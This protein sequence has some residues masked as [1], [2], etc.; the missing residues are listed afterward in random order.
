MRKT[1]NEEKMWWS[2]TSVFSPLLTQ[3]VWLCN[4]LIQGKAT[5]VCPY[6][7]LLRRRQDIPGCSGPGGAWKV[8]SGS[9]PGLPPVSNLPPPQLF[10]TLVSLSP[11]SLPVLQ[12]P[13][14]SSYASCFCQT[15]FP[16]HFLSLA[17]G[18]KVAIDHGARLR[19]EVKQIDRLQVP[20]PEFQ[21]W[22]C[23]LLAGR[24]LQS[25][26]CVPQALVSSSVKWNNNGT[27]L[28]NLWWLDESFMVSAWHG[29]WQSWMPAN[30]II[31][32]LLQWISTRQ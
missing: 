27:K 22:C 28:R 23:S 4:P 7:H 12:T 9:S 5:Q 25:P 11:S 21:V 32:L 26:T 3:N 29:S 18:F 10:L 19:P 17:P 1:L 8:P 6:L 15:A 13:R 14:V 2:E 20:P 31:L 30:I 16:Q 24:T